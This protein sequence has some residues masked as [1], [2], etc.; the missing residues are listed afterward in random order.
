MSRTAPAEMATTADGH[1][2][3]DAAPLMLDDRQKSS[4]KRIAIG[5]DKFYD[6]HDP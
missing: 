4:M 3:R 2:E 5:A 6:T 1:A